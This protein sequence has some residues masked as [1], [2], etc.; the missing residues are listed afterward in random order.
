MEVGV[1]FSLLQVP[2]LLAGLGGA[3]LS[4]RVSRGVARKRWSLDRCWAPALRSPRRGAGLAAY[5][6]L[7]LL[8]GISSCVEPI[9]TGYINRPDRL[10]SAG[11]RCSRLR[12]CSE[13]WSWPR[14]CSRLGYATDQWG[15]GEAFTI[16]SVMTLLSVLVF[17]G[18]LLWR[19]A[20]E[21]EQAPAAEHSAAG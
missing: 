2:I 10:R 20:R 1:F 3:L 21:P 13:A 15:I 17:G 19:A 16:G 5:A 11:P 6:A 14:S 9:A 8:I 12:A 7:P 4:G 18:P